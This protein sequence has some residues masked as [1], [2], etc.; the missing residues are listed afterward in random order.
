[1]RVAVR[2]KLDTFAR[3]AFLIW[4]LGLASF[5]PCR[6]LAAATSFYPVY[7]REAALWL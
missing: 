4:V 7:R 2:L 6:Y 1:M 3:E 5:S